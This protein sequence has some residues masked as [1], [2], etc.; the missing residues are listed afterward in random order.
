MREG[1]EMWRIIIWMLCRKNDDYI[2]AVKFRDEV[3]VIKIEKYVPTEK[4]M[5]KWKNVL[6]GTRTP[7]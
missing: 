7:D 3:Y 1:D 4:Q 6:A 2:K 5:E